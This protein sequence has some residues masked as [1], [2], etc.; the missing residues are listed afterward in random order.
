MVKPL[1]DVTKPIYKL[2]LRTS[3]HFKSVFWY[4]QVQKK[5]V[6]CELATEHA[7]QATAA[8]EQSRV[9]L[10]QAAAEISRL[11]ADNKRYQQE[12]TYYLLHYMT[13]SSQLY[14]IPCSPS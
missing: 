7:G 6:L 9:L 11:E 4:Q 1:F 3:I 8:A 2:I 13:Y 5:R 12:V 10:A 14:E